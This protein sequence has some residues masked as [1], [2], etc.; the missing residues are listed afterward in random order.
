MILHENAGLWMRHACTGESAR[1]R[2]ISACLG[3]VL[4]SAMCSGD[5]DAGCHGVPR[6]H[7]G[8]IVLILPGA[9]WGCLGSLY[10]VRRWPERES[11]RP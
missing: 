9:E 2:R 7:R 10:A 8:D 4:E 6:F 5:P 11:A 3:E 1:V